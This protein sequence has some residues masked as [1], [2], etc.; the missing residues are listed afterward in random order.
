MIKSIDQDTL[1]KEAAMKVIVAGGSGLVGRHLVARLVEEGHEAVVLSRRPRTCRAGARALRWDGRTAE[2]AWTRE[3][4][5]ASAVINLSGESVGRPW[6]RRHR[7]AIVQSRIEST[8]ALVS[9][10]AGL[11]PEERPPVLVN[12]SGIDYAGDSGD[13][14]VTEHA[15]PGSTFLAGVCEQ[16]EASAC[17]A[18][19]LGV[20][21]V[22][23]RTPFV[24]AGDA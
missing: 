9:A 15:E 18:L 22:L 10:M 4:A 2:G 19:A 24:V 13:T 20:R 23:V 16:W 21:V 5:G 14:L 17:A 7:R 11:H 3:L 6:T 8:G 12:A 1:A